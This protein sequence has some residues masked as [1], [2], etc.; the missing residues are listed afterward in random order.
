M[1]YVTI[2][3]DKHGK[4]VGVAHNGKSL[5]PE[6]DEDRAKHKVVVT[7]RHD[8]TR[9]GHTGSGSGSSSG[10]GSQGGTDPC[11]IMDAATGRVWCWC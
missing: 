7:L 11:C 10:G 2:E 1:A 4:I 9:G 5:Q 3:L 6:A 8:K